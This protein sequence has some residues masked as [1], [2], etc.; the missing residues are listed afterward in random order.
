MNS[1]L[2]DLTYIGSRD[3]VS[4]ED[5]QLFYLLLHIQ[6]PQ[7]E[8]EK[9]L[10][11]NLSLVIDCSTSM[12]GDRL[13]SVKSAA[14]AIIEG[15]GPEDKISIVSFSDR[16]E[17]IYPSSTVENKIAAA[18]FINSIIASGGTE[19]FQGLEKGFNEIRKSRL[20]EYNNH[21]ILLTDGRTYGDTKE[22]IEL[23]KE[24]AE[25]S[26]DISA[27]GI[28]ADW[29]DAF[30]DKL[31]S[32][33]GSQAIYIERPSQAMRYLQEKI[34]GLGVIFASRFRLIHN[35]LPNV[36][37]KSAFKI[38]P[39]AQHFT[40]DGLDIRLGSLQANLPLTLLLE[41]EIHVESHDEAV[42]IPVKFLTDIPSMR[43][44]EYPVEI[45]CVL[46]VKLTDEL[47]DPPAQI[48][49]AV[50]ALSLY[51]MNERIWRDIE[52]GDMQ[53]ATKRL[54]QFSTRLLEAGHEDL[55][56]QVELETERLKI[57]G[58]Y[59]ETVRK[60]LKFGTR[61]LITQNLSTDQ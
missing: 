8:E 59:S 52:D 26:I 2:L 41:F 45:N 38:S 42:E 23:A 28:G 31:V 18:A 60:R 16:A 1:N 24:A 44:K 32:L 25:Q 40:P 6:R 58:A 19:I 13:S 11:R 3:Y 39:Y 54:H 57:L 30:L 34:E 17:V 9:Y 61:A 14:I 33:S 5:F 53:L 56:E 12:K 20:S 49:E 48:V 21:I 36:E 50:R 55:A 10:P 35:F 27:F 15:I 46:P 43:I 51:R 29:N 7:L 47:P 4:H 37:L 22:C